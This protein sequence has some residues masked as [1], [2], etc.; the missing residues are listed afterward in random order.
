MMASQRWWNP[1]ALRVLRR[2]N[3]YN[4]SRSELVSDG[5]PEAPLETA[6]TVP[7][8]RDDDLTERHVR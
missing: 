3:R 6:E 1:R 8:A 5:I 7:Y 2:A 4:V